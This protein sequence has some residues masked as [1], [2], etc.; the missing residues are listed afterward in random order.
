VSEGR[1]L[2]VAALQSHAAYLDQ[3]QN[4]LTQQLAIDDT[5]LQFDDILGL[6][7]GTRLV[8]DGDALG[9]PPQLPT[10]SE[11][12]AAVTASNPKVLAARQAVEK[13]KA[14]VSVARDAYIPDISGLA[15]YSY[16]SGIPFLVHNFGTFGTVVSYTSSTAGRGKRS[17]NRRRSSS[18]WQRLSCS[19][20]NRM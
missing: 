8:L 6:P 15:R 1:S 12:I 14:G 7:L 3:L 16:Q 19:K 13:A 20:R 9:Q 2:D 5:M 18:R 17:S 11:A 4:V 10:R